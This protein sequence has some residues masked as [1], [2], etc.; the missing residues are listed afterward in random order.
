MLLNFAY[1]LPVV[2]D[3]TSISQEARTK[4]HPE[5]FGFVHRDK[6]LASIT[7]VLAVWEHVH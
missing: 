5:C 7:E 6:C 4:T 3:E 2:C 1:Y